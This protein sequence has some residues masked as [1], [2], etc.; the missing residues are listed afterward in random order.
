MADSGYLAMRLQV[1]VNG[2]DATVISLAVIADPMGELERM[3]PEDIGRYLMEAYGRI[4]TDLYRQL[5]ANYGAELA[6]A[7]AGKAVVH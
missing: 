7:G 4:A 6:A 2:V 5:W 3:G 1:R